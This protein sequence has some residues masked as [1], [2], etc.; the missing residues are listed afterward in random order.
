M[1]SLNISSIIWRVGKYIVKLFLTGQI[2]LK[3]TSSV[4]YI[5]W[6]ISIQTRVLLP[7]INNNEDILQNWQRFRY[8]KH[9]I[10]R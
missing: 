9:D 7:G 10:I 3:Y 4:K 6:H 5:G 1:V 8:A 2:L